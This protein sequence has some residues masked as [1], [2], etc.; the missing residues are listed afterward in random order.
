LT[1]AEYETI[2]PGF[3]FAAVQ[4]H[5]R[6]VR[7]IAAEIGAHLHIHVNAQ[8]LKSDKDRR[9]QDIATYV[10]S[11]SGLADSLS[12]SGL[13]IFQGITYPA[14][15]RLLK[16]NLQQLPRRADA[17]VRCTEPFDRLVIKWDGQVTACCADFD[18][19]FVVGDFK[20]Q[21]L[22]D[23]WNSPRMN[24]LRTTVRERRYITMPHCRSCPRFYSD[25]FTVLFKRN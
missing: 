3:S 10:Q 9:M 18:A 15:G 16:A 6:R 11:W 22:P 19:R 25:E 24:L 12:V 21:R 1:S 17:Q 8:I 13:S 23:I 5:V 7:A 4:N 20:N 2:R 14:G